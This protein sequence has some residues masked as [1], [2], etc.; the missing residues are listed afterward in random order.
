MALCFFGGAV[1]RRACGAVIWNDQILMVRHVH[2]GRD[3]WTLP[4]GGIKFLEKPARAAEREVL[5][6]T[7]LSVSA[8]RFLFTSQTS[9]TQS[10]CYLMTEPADPDSVAVGVD[11]EQRHL[12]PSER[13]LQ[14]VKWHSFESMQND[15]HVA[16]VLEALKDELET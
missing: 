2:D 13:M 14:D 1:R 15:V 4:G 9:R 16:Q 8:K 5:E 7:G 6:E 3:Y 10:L 11:P 12:D